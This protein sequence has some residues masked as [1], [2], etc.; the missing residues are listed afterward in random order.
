LASTML[1]SSVRSPILFVDEL[2]SNLDFEK[3]EG[4]VARLRAK[5]A[6]SNYS[7][8]CVSHDLEMVEKLEKEKVLLLKR[9]LQGN[10]HGSYVGVAEACKS[11][12]EELT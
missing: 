1:L 8:I 7:C 4:L 12:R 10:S 11:V 3:K 6:D 5:C 2:G 9:E